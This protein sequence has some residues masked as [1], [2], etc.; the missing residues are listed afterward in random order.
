MHVI[1]YHQNMSYHITRC[2]SS[3]LFLESALLIVTVLCFWNLLATGLFILYHLKT[4]WRLVLSADHS[5]Q[6][7]C[8][9]IALHPAMFS[10]VRFMFRCVFR[11]LNLIHVEMSRHLKTWLPKQVGE[12]KWRISQVSH[13][14]PCNLFYQHISTF[15]I[16]IIQPFLSTF[17][18]NFY[19][20]I[21]INSINLFHIKKYSIVMC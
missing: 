16:T 3:S 8:C 19:Q 17:F 18:N 15:S 6:V 4:C 13:I 21:S 1:S 14:L 11:Y 10:F 2:I 5:W 7:S 9:T 20:H 12:R